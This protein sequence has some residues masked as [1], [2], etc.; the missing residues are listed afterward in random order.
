M[1]HPFYIIVVMVCAFFLV[2]WV[3]ADP[4]TKESPAAKPFVLTVWP[5][6]IFVL[7]RHPIYLRVALENRTDQDRFIRFWFTPI[8]FG[9]KTD[10]HCLLMRC[11]NHKTRKDAQ[12]TGIPPGKTVDDAQNKESTS[13][14][15]ARSFTGYTVNMAQFCDLPPGDYSLVMQYDTS[16][17]PQ[18][19]QPDKRAWHG[20]TNK[21][22]VNVL[23]RRSRS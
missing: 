12:Y 21:V 6:R 3:K 22:L 7:Y 2:Q 23:I 1:R 19:M 20:K 8:P 15:Y 9:P 17:V 10:L 13:E 14:V 16:Y 18:R 11:Y 5:Q 4:A